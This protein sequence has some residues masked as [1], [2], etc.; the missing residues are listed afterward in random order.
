MSDFHQMFK[1]YGFEVKPLPSNYDPDTYAWRLMN[2]YR[3]RED[4]SYAT[5][6]EWHSAGEFS[7]SSYR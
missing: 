3:E 5:S 6:T 7:S 2:P 4:V 1:D